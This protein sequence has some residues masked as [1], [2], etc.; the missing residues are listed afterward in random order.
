MTTSV[1]TFLQPF[2]VAGYTDELPAGKYGGLADDDV[3]QSDSFAALL[4]IL[5]S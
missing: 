4:M 3:M 1:V 2:V 5:P